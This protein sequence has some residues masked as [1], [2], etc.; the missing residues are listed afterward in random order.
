VVPVAE[1][2][3]EGYRYYLEAMKGGPGNP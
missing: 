2:E 3:L 1:D